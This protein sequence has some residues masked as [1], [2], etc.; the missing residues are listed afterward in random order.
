M[1]EL[2]LGRIAQTSQMWSCPRRRVSLCYRLSQI[3]L[4]WGENLTT[5]S[6]INISREEIL[7]KRRGRQP[8]NIPGQMAIYCCQRVCGYAWK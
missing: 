7:E 6:S 5:V 1:L 2:V 3:G 8:I 4:W